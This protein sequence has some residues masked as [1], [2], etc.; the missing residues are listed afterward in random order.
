MLFTILY[1][2]SLENSK[3]ALILC[4]SIRFA[5]LIFAR[6]KQAGFNACLVTGETDIPKRKHIINSHSVAVCQVQA[7]SVGVDE[8]QT[9][10]SNLIIMEEIEDKTL[11]RQAR[12]RIVRQGQGKHVRVIELVVPSVN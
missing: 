7:T 2:L 6:V 5:E 11:R 3:N 9:T 12:W 4:R 10:K 1:R 8:L